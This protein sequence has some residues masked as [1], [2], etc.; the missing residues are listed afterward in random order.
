[1]SFIIEE[2]LKVWFIALLIIDLAA[3]SLDFKVIAEIVA[4]MALYITFVAGLLIKWVEEVIGP[5][6]LIHSVPQKEEVPR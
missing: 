1:M 6:R 4:K 5:K 2:S 3:Y